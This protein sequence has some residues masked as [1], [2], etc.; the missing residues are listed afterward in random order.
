M[1]TPDRARRRAHFDI[2][3]RLWPSRSRP[4]LYGLLSFGVVRRTREIGV[5]VRGGWRPGARCH[6]MIFGRQGAWT[7]CSVSALRDRGAMTSARFVAKPAVMT[8]ADRSG[9]I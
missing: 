4:W 2:I 3:W 9:D 7:P 5:R 6:H 1:P 8:Y